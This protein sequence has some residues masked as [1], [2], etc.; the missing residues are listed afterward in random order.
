MPDATAQVG[1]R[2]RAMRLARGW[3]LEELASRA[4]MSPS[5]L[6]RLEAGKRQGSLELLVPLTRQLGVRIDDLLPGEPADP[7]IRRPEKYLDG[8][9]MVPLAPEASHLATYKITFSPVT[10]PPEP[11][12]H[13]GHEWLY[14]L[15]G[16]LRLILGEQDLVLKTGEAAEFD[17]RTPHAMMAAGRRPAQIISIF[18]AEGER[19][20]T[21]IGSDHAL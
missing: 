8:M 16:Q 7:R 18:N 21:D 2:L 3:T 10:E 13:N 14:V 15:S 17:T 20:H 4:Q 9:V 19:L 12:V 6:S 1:P 5:T 11:K